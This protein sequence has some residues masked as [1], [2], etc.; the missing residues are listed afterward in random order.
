MTYFSLKI[1]RNC[2]EIGGF[3]DFPTTV[4]RAKKF[5]WLNFHQDGSKD[6][7]DARAA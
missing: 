7:C 2:Q 5:L 3:G 6:H 1:F 4:K